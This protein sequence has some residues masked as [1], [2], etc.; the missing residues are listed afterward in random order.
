M[1]FRAHRCGTN[2]LVPRLADLLSPGCGLHLHILPSA[3]AGFSERFQASQ[4]RQVSSPAVQP[5]QSPSDLIK[6]PSVAS[7]EEF[8][9]GSHVSFTSIGLSR[10]VASALDAAGFH[11][12]SRVQVSM[13]LLPRRGRQSS[14]GPVARSLPQEVLP[15]YILVLQELSAG[16]LREGRD[17]ALSAETGSGKTLAYLTPILSKLWT[18]APSPRY[19]PH[20]CA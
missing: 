5:L 11:K 1:C 13:P 2:S 6:Q 17:V 7:A 12:P 9:A 20:C 4:P 15:P 18:S 3:K 8:L 14:R 16:P 10:E 19:A